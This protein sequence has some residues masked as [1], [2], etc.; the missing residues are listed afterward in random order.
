MKSKVLKFS[1]SFYAVWSFLFFFSLQVYS[2][3][4]QVNTTTAFNQRDA[5]IAINSVGQ[6][7][8]VW[9]NEQDGQEPAT[10]SGTP[11]GD[12][13][14]RRYNTGTP[15][16]PVAGVE[17]IH[18][19]GSL[20]FDSTS[21]TI[22]MNSGGDGA[23]IYSL[24]HA[25]DS[26]TDIRGKNFNFGTGIA[27]SGVDVDRSALG[28]IYP[29]SAIND[30]GTVA[31]TW[32]SYTGTNYDV[33]SDNPYSGLDYVAN[34]ST[35]NTEWKSAIAIDEGGNTVTVWQED[36]GKIYA[37]N[38][39]PAQGVVKSRYQINSNSAIT[40]TNPEIAMGDD[41]YFTVA[42]QG[43]DGN[44]YM[45][46]FTPGGEGFSVDRMVNT[47]TANTQV[48]P[49]IAKDSDGNFVV[50]WV[51]ID[52]ANN[53]I[54]SATYDRLGTSITGETLRATTTDDPRTNGLQ[55]L[56]D[57]KVDV[58]DSGTFAIAWTDYDAVD[59]NDV[60]F[61]VFTEASF[62]T[63]VTTATAVWTGGTGNW[64]VGTNWDIDPTV[65]QNGVETYLVKIDDASP[66][67]SVVT[68]TAAQTITDLVVDANDTLSLNNGVILLF[69]GSSSII[70]NSG[71]INLNST[72]GTT[73]L[74]IDSQNALLVGGGNVTLGAT[75]QN[76]YIYGFNNTEHFINADNMIQGRGYIGNNGLSFANS[77]TVDANTG[78]IVV[79]LLA[80]GNSNTGIMQASSTGTLQLN[81]ATIDNNGGTVQALTGALVTLNGVNLSGG[82][83]TTVG[84]GVVK[85][86]SASSTVDGS[87]NAVTIEG[88]FTQESGGLLN[89]NGTIINDA[90]WSVNTTG[91]NSEVKLIGD[92]TL[93]GSG[94]LIFGLG[95]ISNN[96]IMRGLTSTRR[97]TIGASQTV[98][99]Q[100]QIGLNTAL[101]VTNN[102]LIDANRSTLRFIFDPTT[103]VTNTTTMQAT[104]G[105]ILELRGGTFANVG[106][107]IQALDP[108]SRVDLN[109]A[110]IQ[111]G[112]LSSTGSGKVKVIGTSTLDGSTNAITLNGNFEQTTSIRTDIN[113]TITNNA[114]W[115]ANTTGSNTEVKLIG[116][117]ILN[118]SG[119][120]I[121][122]LGQTSNNTIMRGSGA[123]RRL[124]IGAS[125]TVEG[126]GQIGLN[127]ALNVTNNGLID[128]NRSTLR[129]I[130]DPTTDVTNTT[131]MQASSG[132]ILELRTGT[133][134][135]VGGLIQALTFSSRVD[136]NGATIDGGILSSTGS[137]VIR[138][139]S[140][141]SYLDGT[142]NA[143]T[144]AGNFDQ[145]NT[146]ITNVKGTIINNGTWDIKNGNN[147][148]EFKLRSDVSLNGT[149]TVVMGSG[150]TANTS[151]IRGAGGT[152]RLTI[153]V[154][155]T[156]EGQ[157]Q[158]GV[159]TAANFTNNGLIDANRS[160]LRMKVDPT[161]D[162]V[163]TS[164]MQASSGGILEL[165]AGTF[166]NVGG[167]IQALDTSR[168]ELAGAVVQGG[169]LSSSGSGLIRNTVNSST[170]DGSTN[171]VTIS[172]NFEM[173]NATLT[174]VNG[175]IINNGTWD[176][177]SSGSN[178]EVKLIGDTTLNGLGVFEFGTG[179][180]TSHSIMRG[181]GAIRTLTVGANQTV[182]GQGQI[183]IGTNVN[184]TN[185]GVVEASRSGYTLDINTSTG[186]VNNGT[187]KA[188]GGGRLLVQ[189]A[190]TGTG[191]IVVDAGSEI[192]FGAFTIGNTDGTAGNATING[193]LDLN[194]T[195][196]YAENVSIGSTADL[197]IASGVVADGNF[198]F[199]L[200]DET[201]WG[202]DGASA[203]LTMTGGVGQ[204]IPANYAQ[205]EIGGSDF[206][207][208]PHPAPVTP[209]AAGFVDNFDITTLTIDANSNVLLVDSVNN[210][211]RNGTFGADEALYV[212][213][214]NIGA[215]ATLNLNGLNLYYNSLIS[216]PSSTITL[217]AFNTLDGVHDAGTKLDLGGPTL[218]WGDITA[219]GDTT[220]V[221]GSPAAE[222]EAADVNVLL[223][224]GGNPHYFD[225]TTT[226]L[227]SGN[228]TVEF[229]L[230]NAQIPFGFSL[231][232]VFGVHYIG[233][234]NFE[235]IPLT[236]NGN[237]ASFSASSFSGFGVGVNP[238]P[239]TIIMLLLSFVGLGFRRFKGQI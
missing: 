135:N 80:T 119:S 170:I 196:L 50:T 58:N 49:D 34:A 76:D 129:F 39:N 63:N 204:T 96:T 99:G 46:S 213:T 214:L 220:V 137:G 84:T 20:T 234:G 67:A 4:I 35:A 38:R 45:R 126:Q 189:D 202:F 68:M 230:T 141:T 178:T 55:N 90:T 57:A 112:T 203:F 61:D 174:N 2:A 7:V 9:T 188:S 108:S 47:T 224:A 180:T 125:Q 210:G 48:T 212:D 14:G 10:G 24:S 142:T 37:E 78:L 29:N 181:S 217:S 59:K 201:K 130:F 148:T 145:A 60:Y 69:A 190:V 166:N 182:K 88:S 219:D 156:I 70:N 133:Y 131:T 113:G 197:Q 19:N 205:L 43:S 92:T 91:P 77:G 52:G 21:P 104:S 211:N 56:P 94:S 195:T 193:T 165:L 66:T 184:L 232:D 138:N 86:I 73:G 157:G 164:T 75:S 237:L 111:G 169:T 168:V 31:A 225:I 103:D 114:T 134:N 132:G 17:V 209:A 26:G 95:Q 28:Q 8:I 136:L 105:G 149:G 106:G 97:L 172:G 110:T 233:P 185:N 207:T 82:T 236:F 177:K 44:V 120:L 15:Y 101:N 53:N 18:A 186:L 115:N 100:G 176:I 11:I 153:G 123:T 198:T 215:N 32:S 33:R 200:T 12:I 87:T 147:N 72:G 161:T 173:T 27:G 151:L 191:G 62:S 25:G 163:N 41:G 107:L 159:N 117:T 81:S 222:L 3:P 216:D 40:A 155:Q 71:N 175:E 208:D 102:G 223:D 93:N 65:P 239:A 16:T 83:I 143:V 36:D 167:L 79:D 6:V 187:F 227:F 5:D 98:E 140:T 146:T 179:A 221:L 160:T 121:F 150:T 127:T 199:A 158:I 109:A 229:D 228:F 54:Y 122:G 118:G 116:D 162:V 139:I 23:I 218:E 154:N 226:A 192:E 231:A 124:T 13:V 30:S 128:A 64:N 194:G 51:S 171:A 85:N 152:W 206:G 235:I 144:L 1:L 42:W 238:E 22:S 183:G 74:R 89:I